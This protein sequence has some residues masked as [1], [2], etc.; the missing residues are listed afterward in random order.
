MSDTKPTSS[1]IIK[2]V[3]FMMLV[4]ALLGAISAVLPL[5]VITV[6]LFAAF[7]MVGWLPYLNIDGSKGTKVMTAIV[8]AVL[9]VGA[10]WYVWT[11]VQFDMSAANLLITGGFDGIAAVW[12][13]ATSGTVTLS[14][15][16]RSTEHTMGSGFLSAS[17]WASTIIVALPPLIWGLMSSSTTAKPESE[18]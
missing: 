10:M 9:N 6:G 1:T 5:P 3:L 13:A 8:S 16:G 15:L 18:A 14:K 17:A 11:W 4:S 12:N 7:V 2:V